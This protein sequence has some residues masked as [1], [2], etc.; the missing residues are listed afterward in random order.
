MKRVAL[1]PYKFG[2]NSAKV[3]SRH[4]GGIRVRDVGRYR[5]RDSDLIINWGSTTMPSWNRIDLNKPDAVARAV[6]KATALQTMKDAG[7]KTVEFTSDTDIVQQWLNENKTVYARTLT[8]ASEG[9]G[10]VIIRNGDTIPRASL[11]TKGI[12]SLNEY[13]IHVFRG[14][15]IDYT[16]KVPLRDGNINSIKSHTN[17]WTFARNVE[18]R[19]SISN[20]AISAVAAL[21]LDFGAV[22]IILEE[23][24]RGK[25]WW[26]RVLEVN[27]ACGIMDD[28]RT[29]GSY[30]SAIN[31]LMTD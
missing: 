3:L 5:A 22:D 18:H 27:T 30:V 23:G 19:D 7:V 21:G 25:N 20:L 28:G 1:Y 8:R 14:R 24:S 10:I 9:R 11:Y 2:S 13:R 6:N 17:G 4:L 29:L 15:V 16:K 12:N 26:P 31:G